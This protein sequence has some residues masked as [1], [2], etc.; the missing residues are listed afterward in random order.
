MLLGC[1][2]R[3]DSYGP[4]S[5]SKSFDW[6]NKIS[7]ACFGYQPVHQSYL[8]T[9]MG[10]SIC[11]KHFLP[12]QHKTRRTKELPKGRQKNKIHK[13]RRN[14]LQGSILNTFLLGTKEWPGNRNPN[15]HD[16]NGSRWWNK[17]YIIVHNASTKQRAGFFQI[18]PGQKERKTR[19]AFTSKSF[20]NHKH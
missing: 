8:Q 6:G 14:Y 1:T 15:K 10:G 13:Y 7:K 3:Q 12:Y 20:Q 16:H 11:S 18:A 2:L 17:I 5:Y 4:N 9:L 19:C